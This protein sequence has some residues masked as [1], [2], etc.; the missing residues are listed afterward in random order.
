MSSEESF[1]AAV[2]LHCHRLI[3]LWSKSD[4][5]RRALEE[6]GPAGL[7]APAEPATTRNK[8]S[9]YYTYAV[10]EDSERKN[11]IPSTMR[12]HYNTKKRKYIGNPKS[13][14][15]AEQQQQKQQYHHMFDGSRNCITSSK[16]LTD[17]QKHYK[18][19]FFTAD[20]TVVTASSAPTPAALAAPAVWLPDNFEFDSCFT[21]ESAME[22]DD[23]LSLSSKVNFNDLDS[24]VL[25]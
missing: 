17:E 3:S 22:E 24:F 1:N 21:D 19:R 9:Y 15:R 25:W 11:S 8:S 12:F 20:A 23:Q 16:R 4:A 14:T 10:Q 2:E 13:T 7:I 5:S 6:R 18:A